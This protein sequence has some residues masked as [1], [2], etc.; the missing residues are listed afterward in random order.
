MGQDYTYIIARLRAIEAEMPDAA[1]FQRLVRTPVDGLLPMAREFFY[2]FEHVA[3]IADFETGLEEERAQFMTLLTGLL[4]DEA[5]ILFLRSEY[6]FDNAIHAWKAAKLGREPFLTGAGLVDRESIRKGA[7]EGDS[8]SL[9]GHISELLETLEHRNEKEGLTSA[10]YA[11][12]ALKFGFLL[13]SAPGAE[14]LGY[15]RR[16][17]D[18][19]N[20]GTLIRLKRT[21]LRSAGM[22]EALLDGGAIDRN[23]FL[24]LLR[25][26]EDEIYSF[27]HFSDYRGLL[28]AGLAQDAAPWRI[29]A[30]ARSFL[31][32]SLEESRRRFFDLSPILYHVELRARNEHITRTVFVGKQNG[33]PEER[34][35]ERVEPALAS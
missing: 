7:E 5:M 20:I 23:S 8:G 16:R 17:I 29:D 9:P 1:W 35:L 13:D 11:G 32:G 24:T 14:A 18:L 27:L 34:I 12:E 30:A 3:S 25:E 4:S 6:D 33:I 15:T 21:S 10:Q 26:P 31:L 22:E 19:M 2:G 28:R